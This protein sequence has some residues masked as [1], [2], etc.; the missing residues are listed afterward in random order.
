MNL[1]HLF[2]GTF[3]LRPG[4]RQNR[5][6]PKRGTNQVGTEQLQARLNDAPGGSLRALV[7]ICLLTFLQEA[8]LTIAF[9]KAAQA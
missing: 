9:L 3:L 2:L 6:P 8:W 4:W 5:F 1:W 7:A